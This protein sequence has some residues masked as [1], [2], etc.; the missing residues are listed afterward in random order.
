M[1]CMV[2]YYA[3]ALSLPGSTLK[4]PDVFKLRVGNPMPDP[5]TLLFVQLWQFVRSDT[6]ATSLVPKALLRQC[7]SISTNKMTFIPVYGGRQIFAYFPFPRLLLHFLSDSMICRS[8]VL[9]CRLESVLPLEWLCP[10]DLGS[11][12]LQFSLDH[13]NNLKRSHCS[14]IFKVLTLLHEVQRL[15]KLLPNSYI[16]QKKRWVT[17]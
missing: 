7:R 9:E 16:S 1:D 14:N 17:M 5:A 12:W 15:L 6:V 8:T 4:S 11:K 2:L 3:K 10:S 13:L